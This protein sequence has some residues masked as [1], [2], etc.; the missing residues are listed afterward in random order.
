MEGLIIDPYSFCTDTIVRSNKLYMHE[1]HSL[2]DSGAAYYGIVFC[3][4]DGA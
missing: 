1:L 2:Y 3:A 4:C